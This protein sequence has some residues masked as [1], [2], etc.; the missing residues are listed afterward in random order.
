MKLSKITTLVLLFV[1]GIFALPAL[2]NAQSYQYDYYGAPYNYNYQYQFPYT[3][4]QPGFGNDFLIVSEPEP[5]YNALINQLQVLIAQLIER[6][7]QYYS[8]Y[9]Q[10]LTYPYPEYDFY[11]YDYGDP[12]NNNRR[13]DVDTMSARDVE[14]DEAE[15]RGEVDMNDFRNGIVF[16]VYGQDEDMIEDVEDDYDEYDEV[17]DDE[18]NDDFEVVRVDSNLDGQED[19]EEEVDG[20]EEDEDYYFVLCVEYDD[21]DNDE[22]LE[23]GDVEDF[24]TDD[25]NSNDDE[26]EVETLSA[27]NVT[28]DSARLRGD[29]DM[30]DFEDGLVFFLYGEDEDDVEDATDEDEYDDIDEQGD[31]L[32]KVIEENNFDGSDDFELNVFGLDDNQEYYFAICVEYEDDDNDETLECGDVEEFET[33]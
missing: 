21:E 19:Y 8:Q 5:D 32:Q 30:N 10:Y 15:L 3:Q 12:Y 6:Q 18:E 28:D 1:V 23:C 33:D 24:E 31:D 20:L 16:F 9:S 26:P 17:E 22:T 4:S 7:P 27:Q 14:D 25:D 2:T 13:P 11:D 29:V